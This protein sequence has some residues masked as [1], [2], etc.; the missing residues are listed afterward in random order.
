MEKGSESVFMNEWATEAGRHFCFLT[1]SQH[2]PNDFN[3]VY[4]Y[5]LRK[6]K[7]SIDM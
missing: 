1:L 3:K 5:K 2:Y 7:L 6:N 4:T